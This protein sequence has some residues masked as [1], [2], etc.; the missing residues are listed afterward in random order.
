MRDEVL[1]NVGSQ[2]MDTNVYQ[3]SDLDD[4]DFYLENVGLVSVFRPGRDTPLS[5]PT[6]NIS[7]M[8][9][10]T[11]NPILIDEEPDKEKSPPPHPTTAVSEKPT[12][13]LC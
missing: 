11:E 7:E 9:S 2:D 4:V 12:E 10:I 3:V 1:S 13:P 8:G 6:F 5:P